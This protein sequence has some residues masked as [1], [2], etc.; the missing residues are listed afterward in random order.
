[1][2][3]VIRKLVRVFPKDTIRCDGKNEDVFPRETTGDFK[4][5]SVRH[6][7]GN[8]GRLLQLHSAEILRRVLG[9]RAVD[10]ETG[11]PLEPLD[12]GEPGHDLEVPVK[13][14]VQ[15]MPMA[16]ARHAVRRRVQR[17]VVRRITER[18]PE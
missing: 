1:M 7:C 18:L 15:R 6:E 9:R 11:A 12:P 3:K 14:V 16:A 2:T 8:K 5:T 13:I 10:I 17:E 4:K